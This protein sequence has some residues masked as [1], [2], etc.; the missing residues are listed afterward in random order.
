MHDE[1]KLEIVFLLSEYGLY[2]RSYF[3][4]FISFWSCYS[5]SFHA[6]WFLALGKVKH[7]IM[8]VSNV[9]KIYMQIIAYIFALS[10]NVNK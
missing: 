1:N 10:K 6:Y 5:G 7:S 3:Y 2:T 8:N 4:S 9:K